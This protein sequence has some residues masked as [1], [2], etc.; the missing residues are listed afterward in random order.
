M[1][2]FGFGGIAAPLV[3]VAGAL[4]ILPLGVVTVTTTALAAVA[5]VLIGTAQGRAAR[6]SPPTTSST[7][8]TH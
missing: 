4:S 2:R 7:A 1:V 6:H 3:G 5:L 8:L